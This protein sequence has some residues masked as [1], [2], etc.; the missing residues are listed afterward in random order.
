M[1]RSN[2]P[3]SWPPAKVLE[4]LA[5]R[6]AIAAIRGEPSPVAALVIQR[7]EGSK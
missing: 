4:V 5:T 3:G 7:M 2:I 1:N 6:V